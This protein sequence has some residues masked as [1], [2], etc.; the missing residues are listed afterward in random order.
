[1][2]ENKISMLVVENIKRIMAEKDL[3]ATEV[4]RR[5]SL[6]P[7]GVRDIINRK[8][9]SPGVDTLNKIAKGLGVSI[10]AFF[11]DISNDMLRFEML[12]VYDDLSEIDKDRLIKTGRSW[13]DPA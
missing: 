7:T 11:A 1:M 10:E 8:S 4:A 13:V 9:R 2:E 3:N 6:N 5:S 12:R